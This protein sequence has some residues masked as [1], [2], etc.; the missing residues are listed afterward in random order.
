MFAE[1]WPLLMFTLFM[2]LAVGSYIFLVI[3][4]SLT[5]KTDK[6]KSLKMTKTGMTLVGPTIIIALILSVFHL[7]S[8]FEAYRSIGNLGS[9]WLSREI[10]LS[11]M[12]FALWQVY[13]LHLFCQHGQIQTLTL[14]FLEQQFYLVPQAQYL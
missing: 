6:E 14:H 13:T 4:R 3:I 1:E 8:P 9:S 10:L 12:F 7:G 5:I 11:G 2:Q